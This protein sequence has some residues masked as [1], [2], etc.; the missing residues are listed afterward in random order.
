MS[1]GHTLLGWKCMVAPTNK[2]ALEGYTSPN[3]ETKVGTFSRLP[4]PKDAPYQRAPP[5]PDI[6]RQ[7]MERKQV[8][9]ENIRIHLTRIKSLQRY[10]QA[11]RK[12]WA[13]MV[14][15]GTSPLNCP[16]EEVA[17][18]IT[19]MASLSLHEARNAYSAC[20]FI[21]ELDSLRFSKT[22]QPIKRLW[23]FS[24]P[25]YQDFWNRKDVLQKKE[26]SLAWGKS[27]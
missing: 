6:I 7:S 15:N 1:H 10:D 26:D 2:T 20:I 27:P 14:E 11:F 9:S 8:S 3:S 23:N 19:R 16:M 12:L 22:L 25:K 4:G 13:F 5:L 21:P 17:I 18:F 24:P